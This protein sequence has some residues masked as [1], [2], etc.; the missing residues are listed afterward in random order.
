M[1]QYAKL[2]SKDQLCVFVLNQ[3]SK[4]DYVC[5]QFNLSEE[6]GW[7]VSPLSQSAEDLFEE[8]AVQ[9]NR[10]GRDGATWKAET[11]LDSHAIRFQ[12]A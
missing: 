5:G 10:L 12:S 7:P 8:Y 4:I 3:H 11:N 9:L 2:I 1:V 6:D